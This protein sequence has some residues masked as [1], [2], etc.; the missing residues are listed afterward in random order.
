MAW[1][2]IWLIEHPS[3]GVFVGY[4][5][6][7]KTGRQ[8][9]RFRSSIPRTEGR[10]FSTEARAQAELKRVKLDAPSAAVISMNISRRR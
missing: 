7:P 3:R 1:V 6:H 2:R 9:P 4:R 8:V 5:E 10:R